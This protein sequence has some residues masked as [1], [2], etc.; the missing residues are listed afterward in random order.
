MQD[1]ARDDRHHLDIWK[2]EDIHHHC[3]TECGFD[4]LVPTY[5][6]KAL[7]QITPDTLLATLWA[8][9]LRYAQRPQQHPGNA[10]EECDHHVTTCDPSQ[11]NEHTGQRW[12]A[13]AAGVHAHRVKGNCIGDPFKPQQVVNHSATRRGIKGPTGPCNQSGHVCMPH[14]DGASTEQQREHET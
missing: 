2:E 4:G 9:S 11:G 6:A 12:S 7:E 3:D 5:E 10:A 1:I 13:H 8:W 14:L